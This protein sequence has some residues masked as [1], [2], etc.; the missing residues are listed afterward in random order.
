[1][2][3]YCS[4]LLE[5]QAPLIYFQRDVMALDAALPRSNWP[6]LIVG[7]GGSRSALHV[8]S[9]F[10]PFWLT[11]LSGRKTFRVVRLE[12]QCGHV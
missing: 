3:C 8:D 7:P 4:R 10:L 5:Q 2:Q 9:Y 1:M 12:G 6:T 11:L